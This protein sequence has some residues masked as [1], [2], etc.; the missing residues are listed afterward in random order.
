[1]GNSLERM[2]QLPEGQIYPHAITG[3]Q[4]GLKMLGRLLAWIETQFPL[5]LAK[6]AGPDS[7]FV[8]VHNPPLPPIYWGILRTARPKPKPS[9]HQRLVAGTSKNNGVHTKISKT[10]RKRPSPV[11][12]IASGET[13]LSARP[14]FQDRS[15]PLTVTVLRR[16][17]RISKRNPNAAAL[18]WCFN[19]TKDP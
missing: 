11:Q 8:P 1:M 12:G 9:F 14:F 5:L 10:A 19:N 13:M 7:E 6:G 17:A 18:S 3:E 2:L 4:H 15:E 16:S